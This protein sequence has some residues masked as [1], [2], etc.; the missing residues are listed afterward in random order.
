MRIKSHWFKPGT[1][2]SPQEIAGAAAFIAW[3]IAQNALKTMR[4]ARFELAPGPQYFA[5]LREMLVFLVLG[6]DRMAHRRGDEAW[7]VAFTTAVANRAGEIL[8]GNESDLLGV[9]AAGDIKRDFIAL[10]NTCATHCAVFDWTEEGPAYDF[11]RYLG[12]RIAEVM[13]P[14]DRTWAI[15]QII[16]VQGPEAAADLR[17]GMTGLLDTSPDR[18]AR[19]ARAATGE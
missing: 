18:R 11:L 17:R 13:D 6:A 1:V 9:G 14:L 4:V 10:V 12:H 7:R 19:S 5:F 15:S 8:A 2:K 16:D 3:R